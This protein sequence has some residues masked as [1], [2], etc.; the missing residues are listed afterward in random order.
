MAWGGG[1]TT[2]K[3]SIKTDIVVVEVRR[4]YPL[5][6]EAFKLMPILP[7]KDTHG[8]ICKQCEGGGGAHCTHVKMK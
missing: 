3:I 6:T 1:G 8:K 2:T 7:S 5:M 4:K